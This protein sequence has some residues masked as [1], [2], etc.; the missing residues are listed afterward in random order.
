LSHLGRFREADELMNGIEKTMTGKTAR[1]VMLCYIRSYSHWLREDFSTAK[2]WAAEGVEIKTAS[3]LDT[4]HDCGHNLALIQR[5]CGETKPALKFFLAGEKLEDVVKPE[6]FQT[7][8]GGHYYG[9]IGRCLQ[10]EHKYEDAL[11]CL[12]KSARLL[13]EATGST[14]LM[15]VGWAAFWLGEV[16]EIDG[17]LD[18]SYA[19]F[20]RAAAK[21]RTLS[22]SRSRAATQAAD[23]VREKMTSEVMLPTTDWECDQAFLAWIKTKPK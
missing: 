23:R 17:Q 9:N 2:R 14:A 21:W 22:P 1:Y 8:R 4:Q 7:E 13:T 16:L 15:N 5:D 3:G 20:R 6:H 11:E 18:A 19:A 10:F 12:R